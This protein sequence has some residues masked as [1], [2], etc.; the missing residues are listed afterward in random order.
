MQRFR[1]AIKKMAAIGAGVAMTGATMMGALAAADLNQYPAPFVDKGKFNPNT[2]IIVCA[3]A[4]ASDTLGSVDIARQL[5]FDSKVCF[6]GNAGGG[7][8]SVSGD[9]YQFSD[10]TDLLELNE[11][12]GNVQ[13][14]VTDLELDGLKG[15]IITTNEGTTEF[16]Q[17][18]RF[19]QLNNLSQNTITAPIVNF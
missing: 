6:P 3:S 2:A 12:L 15:G 7:G 10:S 4:A 18:L 16:N 9:N 13:D 5:Q 8:V 11:D 17:Y 14:S 1:T 19:K